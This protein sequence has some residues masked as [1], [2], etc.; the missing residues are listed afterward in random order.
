M[1]YQKFFR[2]KQWKGILPELGDFIPA[3]FKK[4]KI[5]SLD[6]EYVKQFIAETCRAEICHWSIIFTVFLYFL[7]QA[8]W[9]NTVI[10]AVAV[11]A[12]I[13]FIII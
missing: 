1:F 2:I 4:K 5:V 11:L 10:L 3:A 7:Y 12:N 13:S 8:N 9:V 6:K